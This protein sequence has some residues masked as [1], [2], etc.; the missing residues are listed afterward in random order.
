MLLPAAAVVV[1]GSF[2]CRMESM[3]VEGDRGVSTA[4]GFPGLASSTLGLREGLGGSSLMRTTG[5][6]LGEREGRVRIR[7]AWLLDGLPHNE[8]EMLSSRIQSQESA[9][10]LRLKVSL[11]VSSPILIVT[12]SPDVDFAAS[13]IRCSS[14]STT[15]FCTAAAG[16]PG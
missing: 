10:E 1:L 11:K 13:L 7:H 14:P 16:R 9:T 6:L 12:G 2:S 3:K 4:G 8:A 15:E 5:L